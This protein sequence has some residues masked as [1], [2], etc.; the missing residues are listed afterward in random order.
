MVMSSLL[1][2]A[3]SM[4]EDKKHKWLKA[5]KPKGHEEEKKEH[6]AGHERKQ[7]IRDAADH[8]KPHKGAE[9]LKKA[10]YGHKPKKG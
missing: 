2:G 8:T 9:A 7:G 4:S 10:F 1:D 6:D 5:G 3:K